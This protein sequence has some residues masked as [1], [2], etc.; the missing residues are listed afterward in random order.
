MIAACTPAMPARATTRRRGDAVQPGV[1]AVDRRRLD[2]LVHR[3]H[4]RR[5]AARAPA[6][7][8]RRQQP[9]ERRR[10]AVQEQLE[11]QVD[12][13]RRR[14]RR[15]RRTAAA[16]PGGPSG[17]RGAPR[18][19]PSANS[20][21]RRRARARRPRRR[22]RRR[23]ARGP[24]WPCTRRHRCGRRGVRRRAGTARSARRQAASAS[25]VGRRVAA[26]TAP[27]RRRRRAD[28]G[29]T[30]IVRWWIHSRSALFS[31]R[32]ASRPALQLRA[33][34][35][36]PD[37]RHLDHVEPQAVGRRRSRSTSNRKSRDDISGTTRSATR[38]WSTL[39][40]HCVSAYG[41][42]NRRRTPHANPLDVSERPRAAGARRERRRQ[43]AAGDDAVGIGREHASC[44][45]A[46]PAAW[47]SR[48]RRSA[49]RS[50]SQR[51]NVSISTP[52]LPSFGN[53][54]RT[55]R[56]SAAAWARTM[57]DVWSSQPSRATW[58]RTSG[59]GKP[60]RY[61]RSVRSMRCFLVVRGD[62]DVQGHGAVSFDPGG[63]GLRAG[64]RRCHRSQMLNLSDSHSMKA[65]TAVGLPAER[66]F[67]GSEHAV[68]ACWRSVRH[69]TV[70]V[71]RTAVRAT[72]AVL[73]ESS[74]SVGAPALY[75]RLRA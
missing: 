22:G 70:T 36:D 40:P 56:S 71:V 31:I 42:W 61:A 74:T 44:G 38:R 32:D 15:P 33:R 30:G 53:S 6:P 72:S 46:R 2:D 73:D 23:R 7:A 35:V 20:A 57:S 12:D 50:A 54:W 29:P 52:P 63:V 49:T 26:A 17:R 47:R 68:R 8:E 51:R 21:D 69:R 1:A 3:R 34:L 16:G 64:Q 24:G 27:R 18:S 43:A 4:E 66:L 28:A 65:R 62:D 9:D 19:A 5:G 11:L 14:A 45:P 55:T 10:S 48:R 67:T 39:A 37:R 60:T 59:W 13:A 75:R 58:K 41:R 25:I